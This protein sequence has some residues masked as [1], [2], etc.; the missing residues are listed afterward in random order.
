MKITS[1]YSLAPLAHV[2]SAACV[3]RSEE[4]SKS[5]NIERIS[6]K[7]GNRLASAVTLDSFGSFDTLALEEVKEQPE[8]LKSVATEDGDVPLAHKLA[9]AASDSDNSTAITNSNT[10]TVLPPTNSNTT[11][12][13]PSL[14]NTT[15]TTTS[16]TTVGVCTN[17]QVRPEWR[18]LPA[19]SQ[20]AFVDAIYC[21][22]TLP[23]QLPAPS[24]SR[25]EDFVAT[26]QALVQTVHGS[27]VFLFWHRYFLTAFE[28]ALRNECGFTDPLPWWDETLDN[29][30]FAQAPL[31]TPELFGSLPGP[32][33]GRGTCV[34]D[35]RFANVTAHVGPGLANVARCI[36][37]A[38]NET[39]TEQASAF[40]VEYCAAFGDY[41]TFARC[42]ESGPHAWAHNGI[43]ADMMNVASSPSDSVFFMHHLF[44]DH[45]L[46]AWQEANATRKA[47]VENSCADRNS[48][49]APLTLETPLNMNGLLANVT[50]GDVLDTR[51]GALCYS[52]DYY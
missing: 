31:F 14:N 42:A 44:V 9:V 34:T 13:L 35:G 52:Y 3:G 23:P 33:A 2:A 4:T 37:R 19:A 16:T 50:V 32:T 36:S 49:C 11:T 21:L 45:Q 22:T 51:G 46:A 29:G 15:E 12:V 10:T 20:L 41:G 27:G 17:P 1:I 47:V 38:V 5:F 18:S 39:M 7:V 48:P 26:H 43:G 30:A 8:I 40:Y 6:V 24:T 28:S 25:Y